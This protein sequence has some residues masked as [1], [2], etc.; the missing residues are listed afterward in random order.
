MAQTT[1][2]SRDANS[3]VEDLK[4]KAHEQVDKAAVGL[5]SAANSLDHLRLAAEK[6]LRDQP[7]T[8]LAMT[9]AIAFVIGAIWRR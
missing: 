8:T 9:A 6:S 5:E 4:E 7:L 3:T 2:G 1:Y